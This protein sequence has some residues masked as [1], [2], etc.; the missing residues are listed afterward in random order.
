MK[1]F[2]HLSQ[3]ETHLLH[4]IPF[5]RKQEDK[6]KQHANFRVSLPGEKLHGGNKNLSY[7][8][9]GR[10]IYFKSDRYFFVRSKFQNSKNNLPKFIFFP[11]RL[12]FQNENNF[13]LDIRYLK[14][15]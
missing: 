3:K 8:F 15:E 1:I 9:K 10:L 12:A 7:D 2:L 14:F 11:L 4:R 13:I 5:A 6:Q